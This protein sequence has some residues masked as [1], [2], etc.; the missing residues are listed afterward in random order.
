[1][2]QTQKTG[3]PAAGEDEVLALYRQIVRR[4]LS[5]GSRNA[6]PNSSKA[7]ASIILEEMLKASKFVFVAYSGGLAKDVWNDAVLDQIVAA[8]GRGVN[9]QIVIA[10]ASKDHVREDVREF[11][12]C[13]PEGIGAE[14]R[15]EIESL[16]HFSVADAAFR[17]ETDRGARK[18][19]FCAHDESAAAT[20]RTTHKIILQKVRAA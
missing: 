9:V 6:I 17:L 13:I 14:T 8:A 20:L 7:H 1:M 19:V 18:A 10:R 15:R 2:E 12:T 4:M 11:V 3:C 5:E 16:G